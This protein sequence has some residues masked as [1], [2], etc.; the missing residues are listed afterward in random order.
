[1]MTARVSA[2]PRMMPTTRR[3]RR[4]QV[5]T[6]GW[7][8]SPSLTG[9]PGTTRT[10]GG[11]GCWKAET[12][13]RSIRARR[14]ERLSMLPS[15]CSILP[16]TL[17]TSRATSST[18]DCVCFACSNTFVKSSLKLRLIPFSP[19]K[20]IVFTTPGTAPSL[21]A[22]AI[23]ITGLSPS[24]ATTPIPDPS[25][26]G[27]MYS[28]LLIGPSTTTG[29]C[30]RKQHQCPL[31]SSSGDGIGSP[32]HL[33]FLSEITMYMAFL[34]VPSSL[35]RN[36]STSITMAPLSKGPQPSARRKK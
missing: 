14:W 35:D 17:L 1:M 4:T 20:H 34:T 36:P 31:S 8:Q 32:F 3:L 12:R 15:V 28:P 11:W 9:R 7:R 21:L 30:P 29:T 24:F 10:G 2:T 6:P 22:S 26:L 5:W 13:R 33:T 19:A 23:P 16:W 27:P 18:I 25:A